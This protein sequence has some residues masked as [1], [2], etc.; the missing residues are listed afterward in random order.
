MTQTLK[1]KGKGMY[2]LLGILV[3]LNSIAVAIWA[4]S[5]TSALTKAQIGGITSVCGVAVLVGLVFFFNERV[6]ELSNP[7]LGTLKAATKQAVDDANEIAGLKEQ[8]KGHAK[9][10]EDLVKA[11][12]DAEKKVAELDRYLFFVVTMTAAQNDSRKAYDKLKELGQDQKYPFREQAWA[13]YRKVFI[14]HVSMLELRFTNPF[15]PNVK[16]EDFTIDS[17]KQQVWPEMKAMKR[18][19]IQKCGAL[20]MLKT[21]SRINVKDKLQFFIDVMESEESLTVT[22]YACRYFKDLTSTEL[23]F[24]VEEF[25]KWWTENKSKFEGK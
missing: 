14:S 3:I 21:N 6:T 4:L 17:Y 19:F 12:T 18:D 10:L 24:E 15:L 25:K 8:I 9:Q 16:P 20:F 11:G 7:L 13:A 5:T 1:Q 22:E 2:Q 23:P